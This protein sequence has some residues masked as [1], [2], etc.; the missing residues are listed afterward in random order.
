MDQRWKVSK[1]KL[2][3]IWRYFSK[4]AI[5]GFLKESFIARSFDI[6]GLMAGFTVAYQLNVFQLSSWAIA[7]YPVILTAKAQNVKSARL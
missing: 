6:G 5:P 2:S 1:M 3:N 7:I 4:D